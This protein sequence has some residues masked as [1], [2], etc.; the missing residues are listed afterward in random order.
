MF[1]KMR[2]RLSGRS[3]GGIVEAAYKT[4][5]EGLR[6]WTPTARRN[7]AMHR[8]FDEEWGTDTAEQLWMSDLEFPVELARQCIPYEASQPGTL[9]A[10]LDLIDIDPV[11]FA[12]IDIGSGKGR[13]VLCASMLG[14]RRAIGLEYSERLTEIAKQ[15]GAIFESQ[16]AAKV[17]PEFWQGNATEFEAPAG[18]LLVYLY[19]PFELPIFGQCVDRIEAAIVAEKRPVLLA[20]ANPRFAEE[21]DKRPRWNAIAGNEDIS[22]FE[23]R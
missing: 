22:V 18:P 1:D 9:E 19:N 2:K 8:S 17:P 14:F 21:I 5:K 16:G 6:S 23:C 11:D 13:M 7:R 3:P 12:F 20:Y 15:N 4:A 10:I